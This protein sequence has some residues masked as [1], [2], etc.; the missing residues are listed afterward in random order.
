MNTT[1]LQQEVRRFT[2]S[3]NPREQKRIKKIEKF[4]SCHAPQ[5]LEKEDFMRELSYIIVRILFEKQISQTDTDD[6][7]FQ[8]ILHTKVG[9][10]ETIQHFDQFLKDHFNTSLTLEEAILLT[11]SA[12]K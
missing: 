12:S 5:L 9:S 11:L 8:L 7:A 2:V 10:V 4:F 1:K 6:S 3:I